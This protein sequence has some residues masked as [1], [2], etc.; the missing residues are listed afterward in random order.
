MVG[1]AEAKKASFTHR[2]HCAFGPIDLQM[3]PL[4]SLLTDGVVDQQIGN[5]NKPLLCAVTKDYS[6]ISIPTNPTKSGI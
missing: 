3:R 5:I 1:A 6:V 4:S 2:N